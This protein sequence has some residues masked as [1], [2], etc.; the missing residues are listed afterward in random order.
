MEN[1]VRLVL[2]V[3]RPIWKLS[4]LWSLVT[5]HAQRPLYFKKPKKAI[6]QLKPPSNH[7]TLHTTPIKF[8]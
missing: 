3:V 5:V 8:P 6:S 4:I 1:E 2:V 7:S